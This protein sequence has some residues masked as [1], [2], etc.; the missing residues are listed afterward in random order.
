MRIRWKKLLIRI[1]RAKNQRIRPDPDPDVRLALPCLTLFLFVQAVESAVTLQ[2]DD[3][4]DYVRCCINALIN[5]KF[6]LINIKEEEAKNKEEKKGKWKDLSFFLKAPDHVKKKTLFNQ[7]VRTR[8]L[9]LLACRIRYFFHR[10][11]PVST[12][13][14]FHTLNIFLYFILLPPIYHIF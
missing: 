4:F 9:L 5:L 2:D 7:V 6:Q 13:Y 1:R 14:I 10:I 12:T 3:A 8:S 11:L